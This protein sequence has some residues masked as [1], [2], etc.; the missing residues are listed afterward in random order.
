MHSQ[1]KR[2]YPMQNLF[3]FSAVLG[4]ALFIASLPVTEITGIIGS[5]V[6]IV[7]GTVG[8]IETEA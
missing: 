6:L 2:Y 4:A 3:I 5:I 7:V 1:K 8:C